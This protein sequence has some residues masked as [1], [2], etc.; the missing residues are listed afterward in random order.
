MNSRRKLDRK[1][2]LRLY[3]WLKANYDKLTGKTMTEGAELVSQEL[4][5]S[6][7]TT[8]VTAMSSDMGMP[9][10]WRV[11][12]R[13]SED[14]S[15]QSVLVDHAKTLM[16]HR[17][18]LASILHFQSSQS[19]GLNRLSDVCKGLIERVES[20]EREVKR[21][22]EHDSIESGESPHVQ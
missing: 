16:S 18:T 1:D 19:Q 5:L 20:L 11:R 13:T 7:G 12:S 8:T 10:F 2:E 9:P 14:E 3:E 6:V 4:G 21:S 15:I 17:G 22:M